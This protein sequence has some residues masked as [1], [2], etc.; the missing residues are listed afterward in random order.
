MKTSIKYLLT[1]VCMAAAVLPALTAC[2]GNEADNPYDTNYD[3]N[4]VYIYSPNPSDN[5]LEYKANGT[6]LAAI[7]EECVVNPVRCTKPAPA[8]LTVQLAVD[9]SLVESYNAAHG[10]SYTL[11]KGVQLENSSLVIKQG[12]YISEQ[13]LKVR[14]T[15][16]SE[17]QNGAEKYILPIAI[18]SVQGSGVTVSESTGHIFLTFTSSY[19]ANYVMLAK[20]LSSTTLTFKDGAYTNLTDR[21]DLGNLFATSW[22]AD[23]DITVK[24]SID[25]DKVDTYNA[26]NGTNYAAWPYDVELES[27]ELTIPT[28]SSITA[29]GAV[30]LFADA[31]AALPLEEGL[32]YMI[33]LVVESVSGTGA[34]AAEASQTSYVCFTTKE[35]PFAQSA[36]RA[37]GTKLTYSDDWVVTVDGAEYI[38]YGGEWGEYWWC[39]LLQDS[40]VDWLENGQT[41]EII[42][43]EAKKVSYVSISSSYG[44]G[45]MFTGIRIETSLDGVNYEGG[46][47]SFSPASTEI[48]QILEPRQVRYIRLTPLGTYNAWGAYPTSMTL[49]A[50]R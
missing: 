6:F 19:K 8:D 47:C 39:W 10:T 4:Y 49:Y 1:G 42:L 2:E 25:F 28:G 38:D 24:L 36:N 13:Q 26:L 34:E 40:G 32:Q 48:I 50:A 44:S 17:F 11:L 29:E 7:D 20:T 35:Q 45:Y 23:A 22:A 16:L 21:L 15:D 46:N 3:I 43:P 31:M 9:A 5:S 12:E 30:L 14:Y 18:Q 33:P 37:T 27:E 41:M